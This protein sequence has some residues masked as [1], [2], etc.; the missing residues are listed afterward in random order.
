MTMKPVPTLLRSAAFLLTVSALTSCGS[1]QETDNAQLQA[2]I[3]PVIP[4]VGGSVVTIKVEDNQRVQAGD[5]LALLDDRDFVL[6]VQQAEIALEQAEAGVSVARRN[7]QAAGIGTATVTDNSE[8]ATAGIAAA[9]EGVRAAEV[10][11]RQ[12]TLN[13][14]RQE[15]LLADQS[16][17][18]A[19]YDNVK[20]EKEAAEAGSRVAQAQ[21]A[22]LQ[23]QASAARKQITS[24]QTQV[25]IV[26]EGVRLA[27]LAVKQAR[28]NLATA[29]LQHSYTVITAPATGV[30]S[31]RNVQLGQ[32]VAPGQSLMKVAN[33]T[34]LW[35]VAN[36]KE[37]Q[38]AT[39]RVG[40]PAEIKVDAY[41]DKVFKAQ[42]QSLS[43]AT[44][45]RF[46]M[47]PP[48]NATGNFVKVTQR[49]P[50]KIALTEQPDPATPLRA[51]MSVA[52]HIQ[53]KES[54]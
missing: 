37:T 2:D 39:M 44:G 8:A 12:A 46:S 47:L 29:R 32:V 43:P 40:Q 48:D 7:T 38:T 36:F 24:S 34:K 42:I 21:V 11:V 26:G 5:T 9:Q 20:A 28:A 15:Q 31:D 3:S 18:R 53:E 19:V 52:V 51:G 25:G 10:R 4:K 17:P 1:G 30:V 49:V 54:K 35:V 50:V 16:T 45:A 13:F 23:R 22:V 33:D 41:P 27:E 6:R 14:N